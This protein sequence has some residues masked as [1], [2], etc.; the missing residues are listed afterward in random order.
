MTCSARYEHCGYRE[1]FDAQFATVT[2]NWLAAQHR[3]EAAEAGL[4]A[5]L[6]R[7]AELEQL[8]ETIAA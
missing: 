1:H 7:V 6:A 3:A 5:A 8:L 2:E 4:S